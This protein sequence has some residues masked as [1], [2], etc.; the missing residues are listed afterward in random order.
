MALMRAELLRSLR[1]V[2]PFVFM[3]LLVLVG[4]FTV[5]QLAMLGRAAQDIY[6]IFAIIVLVA[7]G[8]FIPALAATAIVGEREQETYDQLALT[9]IPPKGLVLAKLVNAIGLFLIVAGG[10]LPVLGSVFFMVGLDIDLVLFSIAILLMG[11]LSV[12][13]IGITASAYSRR[14]LQALI[15]AYLA[16]LFFMGGHDFLLI[17]ADEVL[18][19]RFLPFSVNASAF[20]TFAMATSPPITLVG[21]YESWGNSEGFYWACCYHATIVLVCFIATIVLLRRGPRAAPTER[22]QTPWLPQLGGRRAPIGDRVN[23]MTVKEMRWGLLRRHWSRALLWAVSLL[24]FLIINGAIVNEYHVF[25]MATPRYWSNLSEGARQLREVLMLSFLFFMI[26]YLLAVP[27]FVTHLLTKER[28]THN[29]DMLRVSLLSTG[30]IVRGK[31]VAALRSM[32]PIVAAF[33]LTFLVFMGA[34]VS[35]GQEHIVVLGVIT[36]AVSVLFA[37]GLSAYAGAVSRRTATG[38]VAAYAGCLFAFAGLPLLGAMLCEALQIRGVE[39]GIL[40]AALSPVISW[41]VHIG[42]GTDDGFFLWGFVMMSYS[43][44]G[45]LFLF[46]AIRRYGKTDA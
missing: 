1:G 9:L 2:R 14:S 39:A 36:T 25:D 24:T 4:W 31:L 18:R 28:E 37:S 13:A 26:I 27:V 6:L 33:A 32:M 7:A 5:Q 17:V 23:A 29:L 41:I 35:I 10:A 44:L 8:L 45:V 42:E 20:M 46:K 19:W 15:L 12:A 16:T 34:I 40:S 21:M 11:S 30:Q 3:A 43:A 38:L 22:G